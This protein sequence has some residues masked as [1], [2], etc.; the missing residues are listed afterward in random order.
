V[1]QWFFNPRGIC[2][3][4]GHVSASAEFFDFDD[5]K[6]RGGV[7]KEWIERLPAELIRK[8]VIYRTPSNGW[9]TVYRSEACFGGGKLVLAK[10]TKEEAIIELLAAQIVLVPGGDGRAHPV[11]KPYVYVRGHLCDVMTIS[12]EERFMLIGTAKNF[13][14][15]TAPERAVA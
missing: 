7:F 10:R 11:Q 3:I 15:Y 4:G 1:R 8:L 13:N 5:H 6:D 14:L 2:V 9:R 12:P